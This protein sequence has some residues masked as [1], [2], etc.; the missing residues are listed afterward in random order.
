MFGAC[1]HKQCPHSCFLAVVLSLC[2][3]RFAGSVAMVQPTAR[4]SKALIGTSDRLL[5][6]WMRHTDADFHLFTPSEAT[7]IRDALLTWYRVERRKLPWRGDPPPW[8]GS[9]AK[10][11]VKQSSAVAVN[12]K[13]TQQQSKNQQQL[14][15]DTLPKQTTHANTT[16]PVTAYGIWVS[17]I[18]LQQTR[19]EAVIPY[20][21]A[22]MQSF[23]TAQH[24]ARATDEQVNAHWAGLGFYRRARMLHA[25]SKTIA[26]QELPTT[27]RELATLQGV[28][29]YTAAAIASIAYN[30]TVPVVDGNVCRVLSR[31]RAIAQHV[32]HP[33]FKDKFAWTL[34]AQIVQA[35][36]GSAPGEVNQ[37]LM[38]LGAT[39]CAPS[40]TG[41]DD[42]DPL[43]EF[44][45][46]T[47]LGRE[48]HSA[49]EDPAKLLALFK[50]ESCTE[51]ESPSRIC[52]VC[53]AGGVSQ[54][55]HDFCDA[56]GAAT[57]Q[58][59]PLSKPIESPVDMASRCGH[60]IFPLAPP[61]MNKKEEVYAVGVLT[62]SATTI[63]DSNNDQSYW[64]LVRRPSTG[65]LAGQWEFPSAVVWS[66]ESMPILEKKQKRK[67][68]S[69][70]VPFITKAV[71]KRELTLLLKQIVSLEADEN[72]LHD[73]TQIKRE[74]VGAE[75]LE[76]VFSHV[77]HSMWIEFGE[78]DD[79][80]HTG[81]RDITG[82]EV[83]WMQ[84]FEM[85]QVGVTSGLKK[86]LKAV[87]EHMKT[88]SSKKKQR[89]K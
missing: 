47:R 86:V 76:H 7:R 27:S 14:D 38:E 41:I 44:Y 43:K 11:R 34:A 21:V 10:K 24:L 32:K 29:P 17:E 33:S 78:V 62:C 1:K 49:G 25:A 55:V 53:A 52:K 16:F 20:W 79:I 28:G 40:G 9:T 12:T 5:E 65:L 50:K 89:R 77:R 26:D 54:V 48:M 73:V 87:K 18:M 37:A 84:E 42:C 59:A 74:N 23:P 61:K 81:W 85:D 75:P 36:D 22:W 13:N 66:S 15:D 35:G 60:S 45:W 83:R 2:A 46:S 69:N 80:Y 31:L 64:L 57:L 82:R 72:A 63:N 88:S 58:S 30:E 56:F 6:P 19:V 71:R 70:Q 68:M 4:N 67:D 3:Q 8:T 39:Y 51:N